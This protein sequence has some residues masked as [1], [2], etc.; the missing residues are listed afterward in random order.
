MDKF[1]GSL[2]QL[3]AKVETCGIEGEWTDIPH[4]HRFRSKDGAL[5]NWFSSTGTL[6]LQGKKESAEKLKAALE[7]GPQETLRAELVDAAKTLP[8]EKPKVFVVHGHDTATREQLEL[9]LHRLGLEPFVLANTGGGGMTII[10]SLEQEIV[11]PHVRARFGIVLL[12]PDDMGY[13]QRDGEVARQPRARQNVVLEMGMVLAALGRQNVAILKRGHMETPSDA[14]GI[15]YLPFNDHVKETVP[16][17]V[18]RLR[19]AG[20][21]LAPDAITKAAS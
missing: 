13:A 9:V 12:T 2:E 3:Q 6:Q 5:L 4:G 15:I 19:Q 10:E 7:G 17:L 1:T 16:K 8:A 20:F 11:N 21:N 18:D 14:Q